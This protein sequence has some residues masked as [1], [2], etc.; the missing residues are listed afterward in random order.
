MDFPDSHQRYLRQQ[1][2]RKGAVAHAWQEG[3]EHGF[4]NGRAT[5][6]PVDIGPFAYIQRLRSELGSLKLPNGTVA[7]DVCRTQLRI[8]DMVL[9]YCHDDTTEWPLPEEA[10]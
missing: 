5:A 6:K 8:V 7:L 4:A 2:T 9:R 3:Y 10:A 1:Y